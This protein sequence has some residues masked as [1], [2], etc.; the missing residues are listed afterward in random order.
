MSV[1]DPMSQQGR[2]TT[3]Q[4]WDALAPRERRLVLVASALVAAALLWWLALGPALATLR[5]SA[6]RHNQLDAQLQQMQV[7]KARAVALLAQPKMAAED[8]RRALEAGVKQALGASAQLQVAGGRATVTLKGASADAL[9]QWLVQAR[10][11][12]RSAPA[13][14]RLVKSAGSPG[15]D[16]TVVINLPGR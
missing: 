9:A 4:R 12:A 15:W 1:P 5:A 11:N 3:G 13:E 8:S 6:E 7:L 16:G 10:I 2:P 14:V